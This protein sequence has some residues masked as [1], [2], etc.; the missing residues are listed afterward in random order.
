MVLEKGRD[1]NTVTVY[2]TKKK[3]AVL[4]SIDFDGIETDERKDTGITEKPTTE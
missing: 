3:L 2:T 4:T 1:N